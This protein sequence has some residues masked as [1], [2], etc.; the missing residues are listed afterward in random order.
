MRRA[1]REISFA[2][3]AW[4]VPFVVSVCLFPL[5][6]SHEPLFDTLMGVTLTFSTVA[7]GVAYF[8]RIS[9]NYVAQ[10]ARIGITWAA[11]NWFLDGLMFS[12]G[13]MKMSLNQYVMDIGIAYLAIPVM[14]V[15]L[16]AAARMAAKER[17]SI[18]NMSPSQRG[19]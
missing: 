9:A 15:G 12:S 4:L 14:T 5:K 18:S 6:A 8:R 7:L 3:L 11:A 2:V 16:G 10:G 13:P 19:L 1:A 17:S